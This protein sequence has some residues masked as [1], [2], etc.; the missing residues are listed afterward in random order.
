M[1][2]NVHYIASG[3]G[4]VMLEARSVKARLDRR[5]GSA[6]GYAARPTWLSRALRPALTPVNLLLVGTVALKLAGAY[7]VDGRRSRRLA[8]TV[9]PRPRPAAV[10]VRRCRGQEGSESHRTLRGSRKKYAVS[11]AASNVIEAKSA[12]SARRE[13]I[14]DAAEACFVR[15][16]FHRATMQDLA[17]EAAMSPG[18][19][20]RYFASKEDLVLG[21]A[22]RERARGAVLVAQLEQEGDRRAALLGVIARY[23]VS[24][25]RET[26]VL[27]VDIWS[28]A[29]R[30]PAIA[31]MTARSE[32]EARAWFLDTFS[33]LATSPDCDP[34]A[35]YAAVAPLMK[36]IIVHRALLSDYDPAAE[37]AQLHALLDAGLDGR[38]PPASK[39][40]SGRNQ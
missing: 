39:A 28:E 6:L 2:M 12:Q 37:V 19:F 34:V 8:G 22:E 38:L 26:A 20:Y 30:N 24:V 36:G 16:G 14:L 31:A 27:R 21:L 18:N 4:S 3:Q 11:T 29:T 40:T 35:L 5:S 32:E 23:F 1:G 33:A 25:T 15:N 17:R 7:R 10:I 9:L 13:H